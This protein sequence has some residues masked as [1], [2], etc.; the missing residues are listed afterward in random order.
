M[1]GWL[2]PGT[3]GRDFRWRC[4]LELRTSISST[5]GPS[6]PWITRWY[7][8]ETWKLR[9]QK[10]KNNDMCMRF[11]HFFRRYAVSI[12]G[13]PNLND[14]ARTSHTAPSAGQCA[15]KCR[16]IDLVSHDSR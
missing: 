11:H 7:R 9:H 3:F 2:S 15:F 8:T 16:R 5:S 13:W 6:S 1:G 14:N 4:A 10:T 12:E